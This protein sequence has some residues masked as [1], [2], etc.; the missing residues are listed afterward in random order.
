MLKC[1]AAATIQGYNITVQLVY[2]RVAGVI[3]PASVYELQALLLR[4]C[5]CMYQV[6][7]WYNSSGY[8]VARMSDLQPGGS[9]YVESQLR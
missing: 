2:I 9:S 4:A 6:V 5:D 3:Q 1:F 8:W 7:T